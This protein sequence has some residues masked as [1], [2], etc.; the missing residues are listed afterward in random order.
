MVVN[1]LRIDVLDAAVDRQPWAFLATADAVPDALVDAKSDDVFR[2][3]CHVGFLLTGQDAYFTYL[4]RRS[5][6]PSCA[7][8]RRCSERLCS[9]RGRVAGVLGYSRRFGRP[10][11][12]HNR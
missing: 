7:V 2:I 6:R 1:N 5:Y 10:I 9:C 3:A 12:C 11:V 8:V 4:P